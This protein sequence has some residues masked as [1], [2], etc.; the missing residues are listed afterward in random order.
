MIDMIGA[1]SQINRCYQLIYR[2]I[3]LFSDQNKP[4][5][6]LWKQKPLCN[7]LDRKAIV[8]LPLKSLKISI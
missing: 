5:G 7:D 6:I 2:H 4:F 1:T 8:L 3:L